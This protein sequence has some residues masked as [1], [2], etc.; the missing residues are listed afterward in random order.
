MN[1]PAQATI[2]VSEQRHLLEVSHLFLCM[3]LVVQGVAPPDLMIKALERL[4]QLRPFLARFDAFATEAGATAPTPTLD[5]L[6]QK[7]KVNLVDTAKA[8]S[9]CTVL[10]H[11][12]QSM[13]MQTLQPVSKN[14]PQTITVSAQTLH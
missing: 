14:G 8:L 2:H 4:Q 10:S 3:S 11:F 1:K 9:A 12:F 13:F 5:L 6:A 7:K